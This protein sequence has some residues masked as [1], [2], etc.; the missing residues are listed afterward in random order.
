MRAIVVM[1]PVAVAEDICGA[2][3]SVCDGTFA[4]A[5]LYLH[6]NALSGTL[7]PDVGGLSQ[8][9]R[10]V[11][12]NNALSGTVPSDVGGLSQLQELNLLNNALSG[13][14]PPDV[15]GLSQLEELRLPVN[16]LSGTLPPD[17]G[18]LS[19]LQWLSLSNN[20]LS[21]TLPPD[22]GGL[23]QLQSLSLSNNSL[24]GTLPPDV[25]G[26]SQLKWL[27]LQHNQFTY[28]RT[29]EARAEYDSATSICR[30]PP[31]SCYCLG[32]PP[33]SCSAFGETWILSN[34]DPMECIRCDSTTTILIAISVII[35]VFIAALAAFVRLVLRNPSALQRWVST[36]AILFNHCQTTGTIASLHLEWP[37][38]VTAIAAAL[39]LDA[40]VLLPDANC[41]FSDEFW[42]SLVHSDA[43]REL[44]ALL[45]G[46]ITSGLLCLPLL[47]KLIARS[48]PS[49]AD[50][51][52]LALSIIYSALFAFSWSSL[53][54]WAGY[55]M[56]RSKSERSDAKFLAF[57]AVVPAL[58][59]TS[60]SMLAIRFLRQILCFKRG[61]E[62]GEWRAPGAGWQRLSS[63]T[64]LLSALSYASAAIYCAVDTRVYALEDGYDNS[65]YL[66]YLVPV[67]VIVAIMLLVMIFLWRDFATSLR[68]SCAGGQN[69]ENPDR[70]FSSRGWT[71]RG[72]G[73]ARTCR[74][75]SAPPIAP[76]RLQRRVAYLVGRFARHAPRWQLVIWLRQSL[77]FI[78]AFAGDVL[79][80]YT[81]E[82][83]F[84]AAR[85]GVAAVAVVVITV[86]WLL[87]HRTLPFAYRFQNALESYLY[88]SSALFL[89]LAMVYTALPD[90][91]LAARLGTEALN[92]FCACWQPRRRHHIFD[93]RTEADESLA[94]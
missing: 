39:R 22:V 20:A 63:F 19:Q 54:N 24:S 53:F 72:P 90:D 3:P 82:G 48:R 58:L 49:Q 12:Y 17:L 65:S 67:L 13:T 69:R 77:L 8:L 86:F 88:G 87:H 42:S 94:R 75:G 23:L 16:A 29:G 38:S 4:G 6:N 79:H 44:F 57:E 85:Y 14:L 52:E 5:N 59:V 62:L 80:I 33:D 81:S 60:L 92:R 73:G 34:E 36:V 70:A 41:L 66:I 91:P 78:V 50:G 35:P 51:A 11:L 21:G 2:E 84:R 26:L 46:C 27:N 31:G 37:R 28:P 40:I 56:E 74:P 71:W 55:A 47:S 68:R 61:L 76:R 15:G 9:E 10:L 83:F 64:T 32:I 7:P 89:V 30:I 1:L 25:G 93:P 18:G 43:R 45:A